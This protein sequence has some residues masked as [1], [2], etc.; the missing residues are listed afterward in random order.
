MRFSIGCGMAIEFVG[1]SGDCRIFGEIRL[2][3]GRLTDMLNAATSLTVR[4]ALLESLDD[5]HT[6]EV[7]EVTV[8]RE[9]LFAVVGTGPRGDEHRRVRTRPHRMQLELGPYLVLG[10]LHAF[11]GADPLSS[12][13][14]RA[15]MVP[16]TNATIAFS[17]AGE[18][19]LVDAATLLVNRELTSWIK[20][21][22]DEAIAFP[23]VPIRLPE[24]GTILAKDFTGFG[25]SVV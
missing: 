11:P 25:G 5:G 8:E 16:L 21:T 22:A 7:E 20:P 18:I 14:R 13:L 6:V 1:F 15:P 23:D 12:V 2:D 3:A 4:N 9:D 17:R 10:Q 19:Q 24:A